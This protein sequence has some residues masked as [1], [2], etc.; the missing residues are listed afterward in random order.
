MFESGVSDHG[1]V[2][3]FEGLWLAEVSFFGLLKFFDDVGVRYSYFE[4]YGVGY[5]IVGWFYV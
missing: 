5:G 4:V 1:Q 2:P 3:Y